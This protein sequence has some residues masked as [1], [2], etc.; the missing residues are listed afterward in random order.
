MAATAWS[1][2]Q[3]VGQSGATP[4]PYESDSM[5]YPVDLGVSGLRLQLG[6]SRNVSV[7]GPCVAGLM[8]P[9][10]RPSIAQGRVGGRVLALGQ[11]LKHPHVSSGAWETQV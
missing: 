5:H 11:V 10:E 7:S 6:L 2:R 4:R 9:T 3:G 8:I 1:P